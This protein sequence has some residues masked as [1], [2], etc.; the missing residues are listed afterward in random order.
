MID[1][2]VINAAMVAHETNRAWCVANGDDS[3]PTWNGAPS[4]QQDSAIQG[5]QFHIANP[6]AGDDASHNNWMKQKINDGWVYGETKDPKASPPTH[7]CIVAFEDLPKH[8]QIKDALFRSVVHA[9]IPPVASIKTSVTDVSFNPSQNI[10]ITDIKEQANVLAN[11]IGEL[12]NSRRK[13]VALTN[14]ET[15]S[16]W[17]VKAAACGDT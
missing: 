9:I 4:W 7:P 11:V 8:Q 1:K 13:S 12:P 17:A 14:L 16:M 10:M 3:Q 2:K 5:V 6:G 15:A